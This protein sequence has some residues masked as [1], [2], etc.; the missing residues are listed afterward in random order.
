MGTLVKEVLALP[1]ILQW[2]FGSDV[3]RASASRRSHSELA[4]TL[5]VCVY[6]CKHVESLEMLHGARNILKAEHI[7]KYYLQEGQILL[8]L[9]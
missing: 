3:R 1:K 8:P 4:K 7:S 6:N 9:F 5:S 2:Y